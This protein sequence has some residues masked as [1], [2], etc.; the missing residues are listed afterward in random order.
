MPLLTSIRD[1]DQYILMFVDGNY[2]N[3][4]LTCRYFHHL[5]SDDMFWYNKF[6]LY[7]DPLLSNK[8]KIQISWEQWYF[9]WSKYKY[10]LKLI[11]ALKLTPEQVYISLTSQI[12]PGVEIFRSIDLTLEKALSSGDKKL[13]E[14][15]INRYN[16]VISSL[17]RYNLPD[18]IYPFVMYRPIVKYFLKQGDDNT[19]RNLTSDIRNISLDNN[20]DCQ[21]CHK[22]CY[23]YGKYNR[24]D[25]LEDIL[26]GTEYDECLLNYS[27]G[28]IERNHNK[29]AILFIQT[30][31]DRLNKYALLSSAVKVNNDEMINFVSTIL[32]DEE[33]Y[34]EVTND[35]KSYYSHIKGDNLQREEISSKETLMQNI[36]TTS[37]YIDVMG[38]VIHFGR[39]DV[40]LNLP[41]DKFIV[42][43]NNLDWMRLSY[44]VLKSPYKDL[45]LY[46]LLQVAK[47]SPD[48]YKRLIKSIKEN[49]LHVG[50]YDINILMK[51][52]IDIPIDELLIKEDFYSILEK[53][54]SSS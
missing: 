44:Y 37:N 33:W 18:I 29:E 49:M 3:L 21:Q 6:L 16:H 34:K 35:F 13:I 36:L 30:H 43:T 1:L 24:P 7:F 23:L 10:G 40:I 25:L 42:K 46:F 4:K 8:G 5:L 32:P 22:I 12:I 31:I 15:F 28:L 20:L 39:Y 38:H 41:F 50:H 19:I 53:P 14:Y 48:N 47:H 11:H 54:Y 17:T 45:I 27:K 26:C 51:E 52:L 2:K 9:F